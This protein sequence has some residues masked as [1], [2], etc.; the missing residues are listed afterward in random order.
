LWPYYPGASQVKPEADRD[1]ARRKKR[2]ELD[3]FLCERGSAGSS[4]WSPTR[5][6][7]IPCV[8]QTQGQ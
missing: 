6:V 8:K 4:R 7:A 1:L 5:A 3:A 2:A